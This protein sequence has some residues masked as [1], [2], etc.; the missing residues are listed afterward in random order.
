ME[1]NAIMREYAEY[2]RI[3]DESQNRMK[4]LEKLMKTYLK[5]RGISEYVGTEHK[6]KF[7]EY[8]T[9]TFDKTA[10][11]IAFPDIAAKFTASKPSSRFTFR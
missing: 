4:E 11:K 9:S 6:I 5:S 8:V 2:S 1:I 3:K 10:L 7:T